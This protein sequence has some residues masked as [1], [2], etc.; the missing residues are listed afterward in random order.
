[1]MRIIFL[2]LLIGLAGAVEVKVVVSAS[3]NPLKCRGH[4]CKPQRGDK[5]LQEGSGKK[6][7][8]ARGSAKIPCRGTIAPWRYQIRV[9]YPGTGYTWTESGEFSD[10][11]ASCCSSGAWWRESR[12]GEFTFRFVD[13]W[14]AGRAYVEI[15]MP[16]WRSDLNEWNWTPVITG[17]R[18][19]VESYYWRQY[20]IDRESCDD[21]GV[22]SARWQEPWDSDTQTRSD[23]EVMV[24]ADLGSRAVIYD[25]YPGRRKVIEN[26]DGDPYCRNL[27][28]DAQC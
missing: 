5:I 2:A 25:N 22:V 11:L 14:K 28:E 17:N 10:R 3:V 8:T 16:Y 23:L 26:I 20:G 19:F 4:G 12:Y 6:V 1:M 27:Y 15:Q 13:P 21:D 24:S 18:L 7:V 9:Y